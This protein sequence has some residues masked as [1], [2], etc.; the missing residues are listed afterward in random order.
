MGG[1]G[2][3]QSEAAEGLRKFGQLLMFQSVGTNQLKLER[4]EDRWHFKKLNDLPADVQST[5]FKIADDSNNILGLVIK[6]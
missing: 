6:Q 5:S 2:A 4:T 3:R 1:A